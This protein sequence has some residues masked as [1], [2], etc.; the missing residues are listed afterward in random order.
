[1]LVIRI[2]IMFALEGSD[3]SMKRSNRSLTGGIIGGEPAMA[4]LFKAAWFGNM[5]R[6]GGQHD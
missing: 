2:G 1:M 6:Y 5:S 3:F 4:I